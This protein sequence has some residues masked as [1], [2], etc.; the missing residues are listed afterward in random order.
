MEGPEPPELR[1]NTHDVP[2]DL[3]Q[4]GGSLCRRRLATPRRNGEI[5]EQDGERRRM[6]V[7]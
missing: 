3:E 1:D 4:E 7:T 2:V 6:F 5:G